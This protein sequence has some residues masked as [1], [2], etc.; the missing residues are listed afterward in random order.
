MSVA[1]PGLLNNLVAHQR[2]D[3]YGHDHLN[4]ESYTYSKLDD[5]PQ[6]VQGLQHVPP[7]FLYLYLVNNIQEIHC[8]LIE[9]TRPLITI[10]DETLIALKGLHGSPECLYFF[11]IL[12]QI[13]W[14]ESIKYLLRNWNVSKR[15][16]EKVPS[17]QPNIIEAWVAKPYLYNVRLSIGN[18]PTQ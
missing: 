13:L 9:V 3:R 16:G 7:K 17:R 10:I 12:N 15:I 11:I 5:Q 8:H 1:T 14:K 18:F 2:W 4:F 6:N